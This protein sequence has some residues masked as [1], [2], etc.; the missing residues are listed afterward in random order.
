MLTK[1]KETEFQNY[2]EVT[3]SEIK[4]LRK[5]SVRDYWMN[6]TGTVKEMVHLLDK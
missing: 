2:Q 1:C 4:E 5:T 3:N 6:G